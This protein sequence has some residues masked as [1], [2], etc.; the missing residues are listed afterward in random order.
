MSVDTYIQRIQDIAKTDGLSLS[1]EE[2]RDVLLRIAEAIR[3]LHNKNHMHE[4][5]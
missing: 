1:E 2:A 4:R 5:K 3:E